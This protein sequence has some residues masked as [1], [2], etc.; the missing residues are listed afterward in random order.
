MLRH[1]SRRRG[2]TLIELLVVIGI[3]A[4]LAGLVMLVVPTILEKDRTVDA[5][6]SVEGWLNNA[7][8]RAIKDRLPRGV[9]FIVDPATLQAYTAQY[10]E[11]PPI[12]V[13]GDGP[14][15]YPLFSPRVMFSY[16]LDTTT[17][18]SQ[19]YQINNRTCV[20]QNLTTDQAGLVKS[21]AT[22]VMPVLGTSH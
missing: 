18:G 1:D 14:G 16:T 5:V 21:G 20:I 6:T 11:A 7:R 17:Q 8:V 4:F 12:V 3:I 9:R 13:I 22:L 10:I 2:F 15:K 19:K